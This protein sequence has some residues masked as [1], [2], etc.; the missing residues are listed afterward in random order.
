MNRI[1][2]TYNIGGDGRGDYGV[3]DSPRHRQFI[4]WT[5]RVVVLDESD[6]KPEH[7]ATAGNGK[8][9]GDITA[10]SEVSL[11]AADFGPTTADFG[12]APLVPGTFSHLVVE[13]SAVR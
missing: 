7:G 2:D 11:A 13:G 5:N 6:G 8:A 12:R 9:Y 1:A 4:S 10:P 3:P